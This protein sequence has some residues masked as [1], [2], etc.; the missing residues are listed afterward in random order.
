MRPLDLIRAAWQGH[1][2]LRELHGLYDRL[3]QHAGNAEERRDAL[4]V[5]VAAHALDLGPD[6]PVSPV[7]E[8][9]WRLCQELLAH[10]GHLHVPDLDLD[11]TLGT[12]ERWELKAALART[13]ALFEQ[14]DQANLVAAV[15]ALV[16]RSLTDGVPSLGE[17]DEDGS[18][19]AVP[20]TDLLHD[21]HTALGTLAAI[22]T[23]AEHAAVFPT[24]R[25]RVLANVYAASGI[26][27]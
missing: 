20:I 13:L 22:V 7:A 18:P 10:E 4:C 27:D 9:A 17:T 23:D 8:A 24:L 21:P 5:S 12:A 2:E 19:L 15:L 25:E 6:R 1:R 11:R 3:R 14:P 26:E 16:V